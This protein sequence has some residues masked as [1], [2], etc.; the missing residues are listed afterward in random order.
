[1]NDVTEQIWRNSTILK[2]KFDFLKLA[3][4]FTMLAIVPWLATL[5]SLAHLRSPLLK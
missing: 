3:F 5:A 1:M 4:L 2:K